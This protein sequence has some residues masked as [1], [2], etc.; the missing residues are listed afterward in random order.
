MRGRPSGILGDFRE[1]EEPR[2]RKRSNEVPEGWVKVRVD[3]GNRSEVMWRCPHVAKD[4][5]GLYRRCS[6]VCRKNKTFSPHTHQY[7]IHPNDD[8]LLTPEYCDLN[9]DEG[10]SFTH[11]VIQALARVAGETSMSAA[12]LCSTSMRRFIIEVA[13]LTPH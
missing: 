1:I 8:A 6:S 2:V 4:L 12:A 3:R 11:S 9:D 7:L 5:E 10:G 13:S